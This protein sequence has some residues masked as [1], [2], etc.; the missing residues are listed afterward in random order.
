MQY[1]IEGAL[2]N[3]LGGMQTLYNQGYSPL[4]IVTTLHRVLKSHDMMEYLRLQF[5]KVREGGGCLLA[6]SH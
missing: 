1:C 5:I 6:R 2:D 3:A 4:D